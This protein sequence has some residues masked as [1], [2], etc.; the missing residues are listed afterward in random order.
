MRGQRGKPETPSRSQIDQL[1]SL[2]ERHS[3]VYGLRPIVTLHAQL[4]MQIEDVSGRRICEAVC[5]TTRNTE[6]M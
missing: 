6:H 3:R 1:E 4:C 2:G 5:R